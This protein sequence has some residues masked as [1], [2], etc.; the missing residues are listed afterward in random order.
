MISEESKAVAEKARRIY[1]SRYREE[2]ERKYQGR[3]LCIEPTSGKYFL[4]DTFDQ[5]VNA[6]ADAFPDRLTHTLR[7]GYSAALH[8]GVLIQ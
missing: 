6:A 5:A 4:G 3:Y 7:I 8:L 2:M 1:E